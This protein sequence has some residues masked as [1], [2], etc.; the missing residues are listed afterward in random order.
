MNFT[1]SKMIKPRIKP[2]APPKSN[3]QKQFSQLSASQT[4]MQFK[5]MF[6]NLKNA[7][8]CSSCGK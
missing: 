5:N 8:S 6:S 1:F 3:L 7:K 4:K 2:T